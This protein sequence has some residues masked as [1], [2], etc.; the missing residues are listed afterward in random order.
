LGLLLVVVTVL[1]QLKS[2][3]LVP[4]VLHTAHASEAG[5]PNADAS[6]SAEAE[7]RWTGCR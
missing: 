7:E 4:D 5:H 1:L 2:T 3:G 6:A